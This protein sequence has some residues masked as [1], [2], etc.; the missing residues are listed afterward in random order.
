MLVL[1]CV[2]LYDMQLSRAAIGSYGWVTQNPEMIG[3][4]SFLVLVLGG[5]QLGSP[6]HPRAG[7]CSDFPLEGQLSRKIWLGHIPMSG[8]GSCQA[9]AA[10][11][12]PNASPAGSQTF[13]PP[14]GGAPEEPAVHGGE[15]WGCLYVGVRV[16]MGLGLLVPC[17]DWPSG[18]APCS[19][20][21]YSLGQGGCPPH[22]GVRDPAPQGV[23]TSPPGEGG[24]GA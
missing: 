4:T 11:L 12:L 5:C 1:G 24:P 6:V 10:S 23:H 16:W 14:L 8:S 22:V 19:P 17:P 18:R 9:L 3:K 15:P 21:P 13:G 7:S 20:T 2:C